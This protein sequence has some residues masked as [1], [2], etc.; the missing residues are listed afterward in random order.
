MKKAPFTVRGILFPRHSFT[1]LEDHGRPHRH[2][3]WCV[4]AALALSCFGSVAGP[5][6]NWQ[7]VELSWTDS[8][9][10]T[11]VAYKVYFDT[12]GG[13][14][15]GGIVYGDISDVTIPGF[16]VGVTYYFAVSAL[17]AVG[18][19]SKL[20]NV[21]CY[22]I[23]SPGAVV[24]AAPTAELRSW[25]GPWNGLQGQGVVSRAPLLP[26]PSPIVLQSQLLAD[27]LGQPTTLEINTFSAVS[28]P[29]EMDYSTDLQTW[30]FYIS[31][32]GSGN[33]DGHDVE[34]HVPLD[35]SM[36]RAFFR[37]VQ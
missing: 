9:D 7:S 26:L 32:T 6:G 30:S 17:D 25:V 12:Q 27:D 31:G 29:W 11:V 15:T 34:V 28:G 24:V 20:S 4:L 8:P 19:E 5:A 33:G 13:P 22:T 36:S 16:E 2:A 35:A 37:V 1:T 10:P 23:P 3:G 21:V 14:F 18:D